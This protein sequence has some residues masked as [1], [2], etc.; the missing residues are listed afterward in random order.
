MEKG[1]YLIKSNNCAWLNLNR[2]LSASMRFNNKQKAE[3]L[4]Q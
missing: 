4:L 2:I 3:T 1:L